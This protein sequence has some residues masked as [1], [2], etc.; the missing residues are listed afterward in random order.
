MLGRLE[1]M[2][3]IVEVIFTY[4]E[5]IN[6]V[7]SDP[8]LFSIVIYALDVLYS[9][10]FSNFTLVFN[11]EQGKFKNYKFYQDF[12]NKNSLNFF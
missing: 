1:E 9:M 10:V 6:S 12:N 3:L 11:L 5:M 8:L 4:V 2:C 7:R